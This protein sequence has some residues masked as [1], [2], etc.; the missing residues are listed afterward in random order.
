[1]INLLDAGSKDFTDSLQAL[2][3]LPEED[4]SQVRQTVAE[5]LREV[6][7]R[8]D[9]ALVEFTNRFDDQS[10][11]DIKQLIISPKQLSAAYDGI[12]PLVRDALNE[13]ADRVRTY[14]EKQLQAFGKGEEVV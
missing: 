14:H 4:Q 10:V 11:T 12:D 9:A 3:R 5:I 6:K 1:M 8:G 7:S 2:I 13:A